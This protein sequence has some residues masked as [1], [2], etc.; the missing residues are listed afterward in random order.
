[1]WR[2][3]RAGFCAKRRMHLLGARP[4]P[5]VGLKPPWFVTTRGTPTVPEFA[6]LRRIGLLNPLSLFLTF[7]IPGAVVRV[8]LDTEGADSPIPALLMP[9]SLQRRI[10]K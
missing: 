7:F 10:W 9:R 6:E 3:P 2:S 8:R 4:V 5:V 1:M